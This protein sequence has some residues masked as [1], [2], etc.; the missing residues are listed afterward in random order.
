MLRSLN[1][2]VSGLRNQQV[3]LDVI[4]NNIANVNTVGYKAHRVSFQEQ[5]SETVSSASAP[6]GLLGGT[7]PSQV[8][9]G[10]TIGSI[11]LIQSQGQ[12]N[13]TGKSTDL[14]VSGEGFFMINDG[15]QTSYTRDGALDFDRAGNFVKVSNGLRVMGWNAKVQDDGTSKIDIARAPEPIS[16]PA[17]TTLTPQPTGNISVGSNLDGST[18][19]GSSALT[20]ISM[21][22]SQGNVV[23]GSLAFTREAPASANSWSVGFQPNTLTDF[24]TTGA[25]WLPNADP[26]IVPTL[27]FGSIQFDTRGVLSGFNNT[28][29]TTSLNV[30]N[31][32]PLGG[33]TSPLSIKVNAGVIGKTSGVTQYTDPKSEPTKGIY[34]STVTM[35]DQDGYGSG[36]LSGVTVDPS[37]I[38]QGIF[39]NGRTRNL[40][41]VA[42]AT[43][44]NPT[45]LSISGSNM[46]SATPNSGEAQ[47]GIANSGARGTIIP[48]T[49]E[50]S[51]VDLAQSFS[52]LIVAQRGLQ[53]NSK[54][55]T[56]SD[57]VLQELMQLM[58]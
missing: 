22:D 51:N 39:T 10:V 29:G 20:S 34:I 26:T 4:G 2:G 18:P 25:G 36:S 16:V 3:R 53:S 24:D 14:A 1:A 23:K 56:T 19:V 5:F 6:K 15:K 32:T 33:Q 43:F 57:Q 11:D 8:G 47:I 44:T 38:L 21:Y 40:G 17:G 27:P 52:D 41:Q 55:I 30:L 45:G 54:I 9:L 13:P 48:G 37:G 31:I 49:L 7:N 12:L 50:G 46:F 28:P 42:I 35:T 58:R